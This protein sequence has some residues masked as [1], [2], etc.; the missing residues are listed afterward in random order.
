M[1]HTP[2]FVPPQPCEVEVYR[3]LEPPR[4]CGCAV[5]TTFK[6]QTLEYAGTNCLGGKR[7]SPLLTFR[8]CSLPS[9]EIT[10]SVL[11][12]PGTEWT[13][14]VAFSALGQSQKGFLPAADASMVKC[15]CQTI[16]PVSASRT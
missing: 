9:V 4:C 3:M 6:L 14:G 10:K 1:D 15:F 7:S 5:F 11:P 8:A 13:A 12:R 16:L 2:D